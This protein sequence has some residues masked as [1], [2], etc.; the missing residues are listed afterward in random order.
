M[1]KDINEIVD[2]VNKI[3]LPEN[4]KETEDYKNWIRFEESTVNSYE[5][6]EN[7]LLFKK[8]T[9]KTYMK[10]SNIQNAGYGVFASERISAGDLIEEA[11]F[12]VLETTHKKNTDSK[13]TS[14][15]FSYYHD[16]NQKDANM[17]IP[18]GNFLCY[19]HSIQPNAYYIQDDNFKLLRMYAYFD[20]EKDEEIT[21][22]YSPDY[23]NN[24]R[25]LHYQNEIN[26]DYPLKK[27]L[28]M[29]NGQYVD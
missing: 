16:S 19:N 17:L 23:S 11:P 10:K 18:F 9:C 20:I 24:L 15:L 14:Y 25:N 8:I 28:D 21:W 2:H 29:Q 3:E 4:Y 27:Q 1:F 13:L 26:K 22:Y 7:I 5:Y 6:K 12:I